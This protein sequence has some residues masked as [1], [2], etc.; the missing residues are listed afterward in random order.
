MNAFHIRCCL[1]FLF[2]VFASSVGAA[3]IPVTLSMTAV[4]KLST[5]SSPPP[6]IVYAPNTLVLRT[7][8]GSGLSQVNFDELTI[9]GLTPDSVDRML[10]YKYGDP[11]SYQWTI[12]AA[13]AADFG[14][15]WLAFQNHLVESKPSDVS[16]SIRFFYPPAPGN[17]STNAFSQVSDALHNAGAPNFVWATGMQL[18]EIKISMDYFFWH[19]VLEGLRGVKIRADISADA[20]IV[21][22]PAAIILFSVWI[23]FLGIM[24][25]RK[26]Y[27]PKKA[28]GT[29]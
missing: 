6:P 12:T 5:G 9:S 25:P 19:D 14:V 29:A 22:E 20:T 4:S 28:L 3:P 10:N 18:H 13:N 8:K 23:G 15:D 27:Q 26:R 21:P 1:A 17:P 7:T 2:V 24:V 16:T 11:P